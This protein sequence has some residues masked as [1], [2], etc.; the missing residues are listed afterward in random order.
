VDDKICVELM[1]LEI[2]IQQHVQCNERTN[3]V[4]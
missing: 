2:T 1:V 3:M 4:K